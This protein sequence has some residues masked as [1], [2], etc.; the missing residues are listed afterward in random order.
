VHVGAGAAL[1]GAQQVAEVVVPAA[2]SLLVLRLQVVE[3]GGE[4][5]VQHAAVLKQSP[6]VQVHDLSGADHG[7]LLRSAHNTVD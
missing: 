6:V 3:E 5:N 7:P 1:G 4:V 2:D